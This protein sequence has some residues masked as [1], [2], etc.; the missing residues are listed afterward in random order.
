M[1]IKYTGWENLDKGY[2][3]FSVG[4]MNKEDVKK[5]VAFRHHI[6]LGDTIDGGV[7]EFEDNLPKCFLWRQSNNF[8]FAFYFAV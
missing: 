1:S 8:T 6:F 3:N 5:W 2:I 7:W 4:G